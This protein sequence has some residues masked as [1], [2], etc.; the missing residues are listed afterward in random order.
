MDT[1]VIT[2]LLFI[3]EVVNYLDRTNLSIAHP[4]GELTIEPVTMGWP[5]SVFG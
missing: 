3:T 2:A 5:F 4:M 1:F